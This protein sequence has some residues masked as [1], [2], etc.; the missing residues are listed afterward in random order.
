MTPA[1]HTALLPYNTQKKK[2]KK[3]SITL[4]NILKKQHSATQKEKSHT[5]SR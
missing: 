1:D 4:S 5:R 3:N 2:K